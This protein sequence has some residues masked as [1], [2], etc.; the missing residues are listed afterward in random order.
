M[1]IKTEYHG[2]LLEH[3]KY[4]DLRSVVSMIAKAGVTILISAF[5]IDGTVNLIRQN[6][7]VE[8]IIFFVIALV[9]L[10]KFKINP[11]LAMVLCGV[12]NVVLSAVKKA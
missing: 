11:I 1:E 6:V 8:M 9:L 10:R 5:F 2:D 12:A 4:A 7:C 3:E